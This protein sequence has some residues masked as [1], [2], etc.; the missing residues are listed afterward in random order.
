MNAFTNTMADV[1]MKEMKTVTD[2][3]SDARDNDR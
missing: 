3:V 2:I 1:E